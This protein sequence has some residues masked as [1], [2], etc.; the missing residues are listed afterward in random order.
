MNKKIIALCFLVFSLPSWAINLQSFKFTDSYR[1]SL[2]EDSYQEKF[3][4]RYIFTT[5][6]GYTKSPFYVSNKNVTSVKKDIIN[7]QYAL[8]LGGTW[9]FNNDLSLGLD[10]NATHSEV[11][12][13]HYTR[14]GDSALKAKYNL[15]RGESYSLAINPKIFIPTGRTENFTTH[16]SLG[17]SV[18][19][20]NEYRLG[21]FHLLGSAGVFHAPNNK[22]SIVDYRN[23]IQLGLGASYDINEKWGVNIEGLK[24]FAT[25]SGYRQDE[26]DYYL[27]AKYDLKT[28]CSLFFGAGTA[29]FNDV[30]RNNYT[31]FIGVKIY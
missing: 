4:G 3:E 20:V 1:Y 6:L 13:S 24:N 9:Y 27:T 11:L 25:T 18:A 12:D 5:A 17:A 29:G 30:D 23:L 22:L 26:G 7:Y 19:A 8:T 31:G 2:L 28:Y 21:L 14:L 16:N 15:Y 10:L